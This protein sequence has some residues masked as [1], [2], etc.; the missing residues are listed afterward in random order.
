MFSK[1]EKEAVKEF[2]K[3]IIQEIKCASL[4]MP[5]LLQWMLP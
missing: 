2:K 5:G 4:F 1:K 3:T